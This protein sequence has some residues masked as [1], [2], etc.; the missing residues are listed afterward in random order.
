MLPGLHT[1]MTIG[2]SLALARDLR[3]GLALFCHA[4]LLISGF[5]PADLGENHSR[6]VMLPGI[7]SPIGTPS[8]SAIC[9]RSLRVI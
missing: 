1:W 7:R 2:M 6:R 8:A 3:L 4:T 9:S 5:Q